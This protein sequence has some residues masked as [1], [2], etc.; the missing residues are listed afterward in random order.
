MESSDNPAKQSD[1]NNS[2]DSS[3]DLSFISNLFAAASQ[4]RHP[5]LISSQEETRQPEGAA[6]Q[7]HQEEPSPPPERQQTERG[8]SNASNSGSSVSPCGNHRDERPSHHIAVNIT[9][10]S[11][12]IR[13]RLN[14][15]GTKVRD[16]YVGVQQGVLVI[17][18]TRYSRVLK[19]KD[20]VEGLLQRHRFCRRFVI[21]TDVIDCPHI[22]ANLDAAGIL[23]VVGPKKSAPC[24]IHV[25]VTRNQHEEEEEELD[26]FVAAAMFG[27]AMEP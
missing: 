1:D 20:L 18:G 21:D 25:T 14:I 16:I 7:D 4:L 8:L 10:N 2:D 23:T 24:R 22:T 5:P 6:H 19:N 17:R 26:P 9:E 13:L 3:K 15:N 12:Y 11:K 27:S